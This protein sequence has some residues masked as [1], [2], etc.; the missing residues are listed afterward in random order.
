MVLV[1]WLI[2][3][4]LLLYAELGYTDEVV[5]T[6]INYPPFYGEMLEN[7]G[8]FV[9]VIVESFKAVGYSVRIVY[10][11]WKR[12]M[13][14]A[15]EGKQAQGMLGVWYTEEREKAFLF[16]DP[17]LPNKMAFYKRKDMD[18]VF[19]SYGDLAAR[20]YKLGLVRGYMAPRGL[21]E[22]EIDIEFVTQ[23]IQNI[24]K[25]AAGRIDLL[26]LDK[27]YA[28]YMLQGY[29]KM[30]ALIEGMP[31]ILET[32]QQHLVISRNTENAEAIMLDF[33]RG[34][35]R[36]RSSGEFQRYSDKLTSLES[37]AAQ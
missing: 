29:P 8:P 7:D 18:I 19:S 5:L 35:K 4:A 2:A 3:A 17:I 23:E 26:V 20:G 25:L 16:S 36:L 1:V 10:Q 37:S 21:I 9:E 6:S 30:A 14:T 31:R 34:L 27:D 11:P 28:S 24:Q 33:N 12:A 32:Y 15:K 13:A 22:S